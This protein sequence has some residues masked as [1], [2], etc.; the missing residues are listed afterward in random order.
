MSV[1]RSIRP[2]QKSHW[3]RVVPYATPSVHCEAY[4][5]SDDGQ[6][7]GWEFRDPES[8]G[9]RAVWVYTMKSGTQKYWKW[10]VLPLCQHHAE[11][12][13]PRS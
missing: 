11:R 12:Y 9:V 2:P 7:I 1:K 6:S 8:C 5:G 13:L 3:K 10:V 4:L